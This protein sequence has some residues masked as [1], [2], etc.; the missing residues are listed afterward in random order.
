MGERL[1]LTLSCEL[2]LFIFLT[3]NNY[4]Y[5]QLNLYSFVANTQQKS[6]F[7]FIFKKPINLVCSCARL[8]S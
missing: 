6:T 4:I 3:F 8:K 5:I 7:G 1:L 2:L